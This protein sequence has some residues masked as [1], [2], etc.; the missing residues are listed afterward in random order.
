MQDLDG[1]IPLHLALIKPV[2]AKVVAL[3]LHNEKIKDREN[4]YDMTIYHRDA[5]GRVPLHIA[6]HYSTD[7]SIVKQLL[8]SDS[9]S[10][11]THALDAN[12]TTPLLYACRNKDSS[13]KLVKILLQAE[14][15][16]IRIAK[17]ERVNDYTP[18]DFNANAEL[19]SDMYK[20]LFL[21]PSKRCSHWPDDR[22]TSILFHAVKSEAPDEVISQ[23]LQPNQFHLKGFDSLVDEFA[24]VLQKTKVLEMQGY[25]IDEMSKRCY[26]CLLLLD[27]YSHAIALVAFLV[28]S[29]RLLL[30]TIGLNT[31]S[32]IWVCIAIAIFRYVSCH[33]LPFSVN[34]VLLNFMYYSPPLGNPYV[35]DRRVAVISWICVSY[36]D[37]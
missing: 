4:R 25:L 30:G 24:S 7:A 23:L 20:K 36:C 35:S 9:K 29:E 22:K 14:D 2:N 15:E 31:I 18:H 26:F 16:Y 13:S 1:M 8:A 12:K 34:C 28:S 37:T 17:T 27:I 32:V 33:S 19:R 3:L 21:W 10:E 5:K 11:T 6:C